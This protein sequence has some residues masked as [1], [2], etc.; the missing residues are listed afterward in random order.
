M[1]DVDLLL[2][3][4]REWLALALLIALVIL[5]LLAIA[6]RR[7]K[8]RRNN[9]TGGANHQRFARA[10]EQS[11][12]EERDERT[13]ARKRPSA[14]SRLAEVL[15]GI[16]ALHINTRDTITYAS[17]AALHLLGYKEEEIIGKTVE[18]LVPPWC[19]NELESDGK[20]RIERETQRLIHNNKLID[21]LWISTPQSDSSGQA[22]G[23]RIWTMLDITERKRKESMLR[24]AARSM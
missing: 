15:E 16:A 10:L 21:V 24:L 13:A 4:D 12:A 5:L 22:T 19:R 7:G 1:I 8:H 14:P 23:A 2:S 9:R 18:R 17:P 11:V 20:E 6:W 3:Y